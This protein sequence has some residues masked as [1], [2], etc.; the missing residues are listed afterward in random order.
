MSL[1]IDC[2]LNS[3]E[4]LIDFL[5]WIS[6]FEQQKE[7]FEEWKSIRGPYDAF[8]EDFTGLCK[9]MFETPEYKMYADRQALCFLKEL[10]ELAD[11]HWYQMQEVIKV[12]EE[13]LFRDPEWIK[14][15]DLAKRT[16]DAL[17]PF[18][19]EERKKDPSH[20]R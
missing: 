3:C 8:V 1:R 18:V 17:E 12:E 9:D 5:G 7:T 6:S 19:E 11:A 14:I 13:D 16:I 2:F 20:E 10:Y 4:N 15:R